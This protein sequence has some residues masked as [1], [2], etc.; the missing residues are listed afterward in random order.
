[1]ARQGHTWNGHSGLEAEV[2]SWPSIHLERTENCGYHVALGTAA[3][4][5]PT[6]KTTTQCLRLEIQLSDRHL[7]V[8]RGQLLITHTA[9]SWGSQQ[10]WLGHGGPGR[11][12]GAPYLDGENDFFIPHR[13]ISPLWVTSHFKC[14]CLT[15]GQILYTV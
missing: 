4:A 5:A 9:S 3:A 12:S 15:V 11:P 7:R 1:M 2:N 13:K 14:F 8:L 10:A 6:T